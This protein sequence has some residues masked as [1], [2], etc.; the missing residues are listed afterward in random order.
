MNVVKNTTIVVATLIGIFVGIPIAIGIFVGVGALYGF[1][2]LGVIALLLVLI[3]IGTER[4]KQQAA[5][6]PVTTPEPVRQA[7]TGEASYSDSEISVALRRLEVD[8]KKDPSITV[9]A[10][11]SYLDGRAG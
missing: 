10:L 1:I 3:W 4:D 5:L 11:F 7:P 8:Q 6:A 2:V 9:W